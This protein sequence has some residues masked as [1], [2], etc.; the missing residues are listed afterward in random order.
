MAQEGK[1]NTNPSAAPNPGQAQ[2][3]AAT[4]KAIAL[5]K[6]LNAGKTPAAAGAAPQP[7]PAAPQPRPV[8][9]GAPR[10][11]QTGAPGTFPRAQHTVVSM[12]QPKPAPATTTQPKPAAAAPAPAPAPGPAAAPQPAAAPK[13]QKSLDE[14]AKE[15]IRG[16][17][18]NGEERKKRLAAAGYDYAT[19]QKR[20]NEMLKK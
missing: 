2:I 12:S 15:V 6:A 8:A 1:P 20:V 9:P 4:E 16:N 19:V 7:R 18:G 3:N 5:A 14:I 11:P 13:P 17:Y 10:M